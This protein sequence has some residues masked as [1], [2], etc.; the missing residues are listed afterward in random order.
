[1][2]ERSSFKWNKRKR[3][4]RGRGRKDFV[5]FEIRVYYC[6]ESEEMCGRDVIQRVWG[7][8]L[9]AMSFQPVVWDNCDV[10]AMEASGYPYIQANLCLKKNWLFR[11]SC[12]HLRAEI[13]NCP[14]LISLWSR[15]LL[16]YSPM[17]GAASWWASMIK[18]FRHYKQKRK[19]AE[20]DFVWRSASI[21][22]KS[23][24]RLYFLII[25]Q[26][27]HLVTASKAII[28]L[29]LTCCIH[30]VTVLVQI[31]FWFPEPWF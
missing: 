31:Q 21:P 7:A 13:F 3:K 12:R 25:T 15:C 23:N 18:C 26:T 22:G 17:D 11:T 8:L 14:R 19:S 27:A 28:Q 16:C 2:L 10:R 30:T 4:P 24:M 5:K 1:M 9:K 6:W 29:H 20:V